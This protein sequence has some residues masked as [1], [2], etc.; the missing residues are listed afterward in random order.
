MATPRPKVEVFQH[1]TGTLSGHQSIFGHAAN[2]TLKATGPWTHHTLASSGMGANLLI[3]GAGTTVFEYKSTTTWPG[4][5]SQNVG[6][7]G[8]GGPN[9]LFSLGGYAQSTDVFHGQAG[10][11]NILW[12]ASGKAALFLDDGFS[13]GVDSQR[14]TNINVIQCAAG[15]KIVDLTSTRYSMGNIRIFGGTGNDVMMSS[16]GDDTLVAGKGNDYI[17]GG[18]GNDTLVYNATK[19]LGFADTIIGA[20]G[21]DTLKVALSGAQYTAAVRAELKAYD[22][23]IADSNH[24][25]D[26]FHFHALGNITATAMERLDVQV[27]GHHVST[28]T[29]VAGLILLGTDSDHH[30]TGGAGADT[31]YWNVSSFAG[32]PDH[33]TN[34]SFQQADHINVSH[35]ISDHNSARLKDLVHTVDTSAGTLVQVHVTG[36][37]G[38]TDVAVP[39]QIHNLSAHDLLQSQSLIL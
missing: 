17:W 34:F 14:L 1:T 38:W 28:A 13:P 24:N 35:L 29:A 6:D 11:V 12:M 31:F 37:S 27:D 8:G 22:R 3:G 23:F 5:A 39:D 4:Y 15:D 25:G 32:H 16:S 33:I 10:A 9:T 21:V 7:P 30:L 36:T 26:S 18:S 19:G 2:Q 20:N